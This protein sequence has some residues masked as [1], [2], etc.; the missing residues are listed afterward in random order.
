VEGDD[1]Q[2]LVEELVALVEVDSERVELGLEVPD[3]HAEHEAPV[4][5]PVEGGRR[6]RDEQRVAVGEHGQVGEQPDPLRDRGRVAERD[7]RV[8]RLVAA[9]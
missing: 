3:P 4:R 9:R 7:E 1:L 8:E 5:E 6:L 2:G